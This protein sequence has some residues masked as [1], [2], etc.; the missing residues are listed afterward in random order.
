MTVCKR[1]DTSKSIEHQ[2]EV[3]EGLNEVRMLIAQHIETH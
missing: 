3:I 2:L 1:L